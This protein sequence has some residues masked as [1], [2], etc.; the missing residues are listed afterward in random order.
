MKS[1]LL[2]AHVIQS[3][4][5]N[6]LLLY[7]P[8]SMMGVTGVAIAM[9]V[10]A[11]HALSPGHGKTLVAAYLLGSSATPTH[12]VILGLT[13]TITHTLGVFLLGLIALF[14]SEYFLPE[15]FYPVLSI[16]S[17][18]TIIGV[19]LTLLKRR[20]RQRSAHHH[21]HHHSSAIDLRS[22]FK[23][24]IAGGLIPCPSALVLLLTAV[25]LGKIFY[26]LVLVVGF[27][28]GLASVLVGLGLMALYGRQKLEH[29]PQPERLLKNLSVWSAVVVVCIGIG[30]TFGSIVPLG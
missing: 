4:S 28:F 12:A 14:T 11:I 3:S 21:H 20:L 2:F 7:D 1:T 18:V 23:L 6:Q 29:L 15:Q 10:G 27:S 5:L 22:L 24:G 17:G 25:A 30:L 13:T 8:T 19:G 9:G 26:G 16:I